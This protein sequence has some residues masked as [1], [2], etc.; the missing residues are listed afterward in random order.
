[1]EWIII[2]LFC[3][4]LILCIVTGQSV[5]YALIFGLVLFLAY[6]R[7]QGHSLKVLFES[8]MTGV[9]AVHNILITFV[10]IG[11]LTAFWRAS[12]TIPTIVSYAVRMMHPSLFLPLTF[13]FNCGISALTGTSFGTAATMGVVCSAMG[14]S[15]HIPPVF[16]GGAVLSGIFFGDRCS[17]V[18]TSA[19]LV[20]GLTG[21]SIYQNI[22]GM[23]RSA[24]IPFL[25][26]CI[27][28]GMTGLLVSH[29]EA[30]MDLF[31]LFSGTFVLHPLTI[32]PAAAVLLLSLFHV[33][34]KV[35]MMVSIMIAVLLCFFLQQIPAGDIF[36]IALF[37]F[38]PEDPEIAAMVSGGGILSMIRVSAIVCISSSYAGIFEKT[39][40]LEKLHEKVSLVSQKGTPFASVFVTALVSS[41]IACNQTLTILL[42]EQLCRETIPDP[43]KRAV[44]LED[45]AVI[46][47]ALIP[48]SIAGS[49][50]LATIG[51]PVSSVLTAFYLILL[52]CWQL[53]LSFLQKKRK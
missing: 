19:L 28:Y 32:L 37:G 50:P 21:T 20:A 35:I 1:M 29:G 22:R 49:V 3:G 16:T 27:L 34:V 12:G 2:G 45:T 30:A 43:G 44:A 24:L 52:P 46:I 31:D 41:V 14:L 38:Q 5:L 47:P 26:A 42:T 51:A 39:R 7:R 13:L 48:W 53:L 18:S 9:R 10:L 33:G 36:S 15:M 40:L 11:M 17:P 6:G 8:A 23:L 25:L 4:A